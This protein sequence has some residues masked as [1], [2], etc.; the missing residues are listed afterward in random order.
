VITF[1]GWLL[2]V[3]NSFPLEHLHC[4]NRRAR[5]ISAKDSIVLRKRKERN[6]ETEADR[7]KETHNIRKET[8]HPRTLYCEVNKHLY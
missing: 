4:S 3:H 2:P 7:E 6:V 1:L 5:N 8:R